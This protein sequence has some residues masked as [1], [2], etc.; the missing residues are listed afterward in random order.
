MTSWETIFVSAS[1]RKKRP[2]VVVRAGAKRYF[3]GLVLGRFG[4]I[5]LGTIF[6]MAPSGQERS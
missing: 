1:R 5:V 2:P 3:V 4:Q 6:P